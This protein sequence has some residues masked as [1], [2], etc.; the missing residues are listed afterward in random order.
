MKFF[1]HSIF[2]RKVSF[3]LI[4]LFAMTSVAI[5]QNPS[6]GG[7]I[8]ANQ[9]ICPGETPV[10]LTSTSPAAGGNT[11]LPLE[12]LWMSTNIAG[13]TPGG[14]NYTAIPGTNSLSYS[15]GPLSVTTFFVRCARRVG[16]GNPAFTAESNVVTVNVLSSPTAL[17]SG[18]PG[19]GFS[20][21]SVN[22]TGAFAGGGATYF[23]DFGNGQTSSSQNPSAITYNT[24][25]TYTVTLTV[26]GANGCTAVTTT[27]VTVLAPTQNNIA[28]PC[29]CGNPLNFIPPGSLNFFNN[30]NILI[31]SN[32]GETWTF[33]PSAVGGGAFIVNGNTITPIT[34]PI[35]IPETS[36]GVYFLNIWFNGALGGWSGTASNGS[37]TLTTGPGAINPCPLCPQ[38]PLPVSL[39][40]FDATVI[41]ADVQLKWVTASELNNSH[42]ELEKSIDGLRFETIAEVLGNGTT[43][44]VQSYSHM[45]REAIV[46]INYYRLKQVDLNGDFEYFTVVTAKVVSEKPTIQVLPNP[47][48]DIANIRL[49][50]DV[51]AD[52][53]L[54]L[55]TT[56]GTLVR[57]ITVS[58]TGDFVEINLSDLPAGVYLIKMKNSSDIFHKI[59]K[60]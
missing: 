55:L 27:T 3:L 6:S 8:T 33:T 5:A 30:D 54:H 59:I 38:A 60:Q 10:T 43:S 12:Y 13:S 24:P 45:D 49:E 9:T 47:V 53:E 15:P 37:S 17:I 44:E 4:A 57:T 16:S 7:T 34:G 58:N 50:A 39:I 11:A 29:S 40:T 41:G 51:D 48:K 23:W 18:N 19:S 2:S 35:N 56:S 32:P 42:F 14:A 36:P 26:T 21:L 31:N 20:G 28:D 25:G 46:G 22:F 1:I 52:T